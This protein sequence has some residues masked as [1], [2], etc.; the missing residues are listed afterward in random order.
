MP[1]GSGRVKIDI[2]DDPDRYPLN[3]RSVRYDDNAR[4]LHIGEGVIKHAEPR[5]WL[6]EVSR[7]HV[8]SGKR[9]TRRR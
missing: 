3:L 7:S 5:I 4:E 1:G 2:L 6:Y 8:I 9:S